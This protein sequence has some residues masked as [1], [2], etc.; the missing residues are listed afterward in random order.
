M[1]TPIII[2]NLTK[3]FGDV[4]AVNDVTLTIEPHSF[5]TLLG[6]S[7]CGKTTLLRCI[8]G[9][10]DPDQGEIYLGDKLIYSHVKGI[11]VPPGQREL[12]MVFQNYALW[13]HMTVY[14]N[15]TF[16]LEIQKLSKDEMDQRVKQSLEE[17]KMGGYEG[18]YPREMSGGQQQRIALARMLAYRP[19]V[20]LMDEPL[21]NLDARLRMDMR[22]ELKRLHHISDATTVYVTHDQ[23]EAMT[24]SSKIA[25]MKEGVIQQIDTPDMIYHSPANLFVADF[26]GS[27]KINTMEGWVSSQDV[28]DVGKF[29]VPVKT[30][31]KTGDVVVAFHPEDISIHTEPV[32]GGEE[33]IAYSVQPAGAD[34]TIIAHKG[35]TELIIKE[36]G[37]SKIE[38]DQKIWLII[39]KD[40][41][42]LY[43]KTTGNLVTG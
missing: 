18:R 34:S 43:D 16:A 10:E 23:L 3:T 15:M 35:D 7:G 1:E 28:V 13:P 5:L 6:P 31:R 32:E 42:N 36:M 39:D 9:L 21:S 24:M 29:N 17:V 37:V 25:V 33:F 12:G 8:S 30:Y 41:V 26:I 11:S 20:F 40:A 27:P 2:K 38:M 14:K 4:I 19:R 22:T